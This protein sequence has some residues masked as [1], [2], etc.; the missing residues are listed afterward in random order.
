MSRP[1]PLTKEEGEYLRSRL[2]VEDGEL[3]AKYKYSNRIKLGV[4]LGCKHNAGY[5][6]IR[7]GG[8]LYL[9]HRIIYFLHTG[10][11][12]LGVVDHID[13]DPSNNKVENLRSTTQRKNSHNYAGGHSDSSSKYRGVS[14]YKRTG[15][16]MSKI[17][18]DG[19]TYNLGTFTDEKEAALAYNYKAMELGFPPL[20]Y[21]QVFKD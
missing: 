3:Y 7:L 8:R 17:N 1:R 6:Q 18:K 5:K 19:K 14:L 9:N 12:P 11:W 2:Y 15:M 21:N 20:S 4:P 16:Y 13:G 10:E